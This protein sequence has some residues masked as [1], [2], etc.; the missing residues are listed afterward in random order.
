MKTLKLK[1]WEI[2]PQDYTGIIE[3]AM[4]PKN[5]LKTANLI[6]K[7]DQLLSEKLVLNIGV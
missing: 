3:Y 4:E 6:E 5:G 2:R 1:T 7:M